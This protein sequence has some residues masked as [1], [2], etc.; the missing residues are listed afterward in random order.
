MTSKALRYFLSA[1]LVPITIGVMPAQVQAQSID[2]NDFI[3]PVQGGDRNVNGAVDD[4]ETVHANTMQDGMNF[5]NNM[6]EDDSGVRVVSTKSGLGS[7]SR[8]SAA[9]TIFENPNA[10]LLSKRAAYAEA[11]MV[12]KKQLVGYMKPLLNTCSNVL[13]SDLV[14]IDSGIE[15][16]ANTSRSFNEVC[17][18]AVSGMLAAYVVYDVSDDVDTREVSI[19]IATSTKTR[20]AFLRL[21]PAVIQSNDPNSAFSHVINEITSY[22]TPPLGAKLITHPQTGEQIVIGYGSSIIRQNKNTTVAKQLKKMSRDQSGMRAR[23]ALIAFLRGDSV[24]WE[25]GFDEN[26]IE[27]V[28]QFTIP[29]DDQ[30]NVGNPEIYNQE[31]ESFLNT[32]SMSNNYESIASGQLPEG[33]QTK[34]FVSADGHWYFSIAVYSQSAQAMAQGTAIEND[35]AINAIDKTP[36]VIMTQPSNNSTT[37]AIDGGVSEDG[38]NPEGPSGQVSDSNDF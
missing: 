3:A 26:Q 31:R 32:I 2:L 33:V 7:I 16:A 24:Y 8:A 37:M 34:G 21:N 30:G 1:C 20:N 4:G 25:G 38:Y 35:N 18:E 28:E 29:V 13:A 36:S 19:S 17:K 5:A 22:A 14:A 9:Y 12:A 10:T 27:Q 15:G 11:Y 6:M 23:N